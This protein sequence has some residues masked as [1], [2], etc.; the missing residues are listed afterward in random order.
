LQSGPEGLIK[1]ELRSFFKIQ[2]LIGSK[3][4]PAPPSGR[5][6]FS[7]SASYFINIIF[8]IFENACPRTIPSSSTAFTVNR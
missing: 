7:F 8:P 6:G 3:E 5:A 2:F 1:S 4:Y